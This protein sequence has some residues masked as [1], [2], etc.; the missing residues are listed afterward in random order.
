MRKKVSKKR[1]KAMMFAGLALVMFS[2]TTLQ[3]GAMI[4]QASGL[5][6]LPIQ[7]LEGSDLNPL[8]G[9]VEQIDFSRY[10][11][12]VEVDG[13]VVE[14][15]D[16]EAIN[17]GKIVEYSISDGEV[18]KIL[19]D[20]GYDVD[21]MLKEAGLSRI[22]FARGAGVTKIS[23][24]QVSST[25]MGYDVYVSAKTLALGKKAIVVALTALN[26][27]T[28]NVIAGMAN[29]I[30]DVIIPEPKHGYVFDIHHDGKWQTFTLNKMWKQ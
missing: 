14:A 18:L 5:E 3:N 11:V 10:N 8:E 19:A 4:A 6:G 15:S 23:S 21:E 27:I 30:I 16:H 1:I 9:A 24:H 17:N 29:L 12:V 2:G 28:G 26:L 13:V 22:E 20:Q 7:R 25:I